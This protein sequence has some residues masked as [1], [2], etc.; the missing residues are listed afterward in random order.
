[1][2]FQGVLLAFQGFLWVSGA[3]GGALGAFQGRTMKI[4]K[5]STAFREFQGRSKELRGCSKELQGVSRSFHG[6]PGAF[7]DVS[8]GFQW[9]HRESQASQGRSGY[10]AKSFRA[11]HRV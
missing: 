10:V 11:A 8:R 4:Q 5:V 3:S 1:M 9:R 7:T 6:F 2:Q